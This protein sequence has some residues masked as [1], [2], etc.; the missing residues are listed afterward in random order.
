METDRPGLKS[1]INE[2]N[3]RKSQKYYTLDILIWK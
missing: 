1:S 3:L 2:V